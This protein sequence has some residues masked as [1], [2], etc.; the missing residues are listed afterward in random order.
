MNENV[1]EQK[2]SNLKLEEIVERI[3]GATTDRS[4]QL[5]QK[6]IAEEQ[7][8]SRLNLLKAY[9]DKVPLVLQN[10]E[11]S[12]IVDIFNQMDD[13]YI[14]KALFG[15][16]RAVD[17]RTRQEIL[18]RLSREKLALLLKRL[19][20][21][22]DNPKIAGKVLVSLSLLS[23]GEVMEGM[24]EVVIIH[25][26]SDIETAD[27]I[28]ILENS[29][30]AKAARV[31]DILLQSGNVVRLA[32]VTNILK[33][34]EKAKRG[35]ILEQ[36]D[37]GRRELLEGQLRRQ[38]TSSFEEMT[39]KETKGALSSMKP[40]DVAE[41]FKEVSTEK[42]VEILKL[43]EA[44]T[45]AAILT[46]VAKGDTKLVIDVLEEINSKIIV[47]FKKAGKTTQI[48]EEVYMCPSEAILEK[49]DFNIP[50]NLTVLR[51]M[52]KSE[53]ELNLERMPEAKKAEIM[54]LE[55]NQGI[56][57]ELPISVQLFYVGTG[58]KKTTNLEHGL[59]WTRIEEEL[60]TG[61]KTKPV[62]IDL[63]ELDP[64][65]VRIKACRAI[66][67]DNL[68]PLSEVA[69]IFGDAERGGKR[70]DKQIFTQ[71]G[72]IQLSKIV[73]KKG[74]IA[75]INGNHYF[76][77]GHY[78]DALKLGIDPTHV[79]GLSFGDPV[80]WF[81]ADGEEVSP[82]SFNRAAFIVTKDGD[83]YIEKVFMTDVI[84]SNGIKVNWNK[85]NSKKEHGKIILYTS[86]FGFKTEKTAS[87]IDV[88][89]AQGKIFDITEGGD[90]FIPLTGFI[91]SVPREGQD[92]IL[93][94]VN[95]GDRV[96]VSN[97]LPPSLGEV[98]QAMACG[99]HLV[100]NG[101]LDISFKA[102]DFGEKDS[103]VI[104]FSL[105]RAVE[106]FEAARSFMM[107]RDG[108]VFIGTVGGTALGSG[109]PTES[110]GMTFG[111]LAQLAMDLR[112]D[113]AYA[114]DG[115]G[116]SSIVVVTENEAKCLTIPTGG[117]DVAKGEERFINTYWLFF[118]R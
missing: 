104:S 80:G 66:T 100:R 89:V 78:M 56:T 69:K 42:I 117:S 18:E 118:K 107:L 28:K 85:V 90:A 55:K 88:A 68:T 2:M 22:V 52:N 36:M 76:D 99:P 116:S 49:M 7:E 31:L 8:L 72:L 41:Q 59:K 27:K 54:A 13:Y 51:G 37:T 26:I 70:P 34:M 79:P 81:V 10:F 43:C 25:L 58:T 83:V 65:K 15:N 6:L 29:D 108:K 94:N 9:E 40:S 1:A 63:V 109:A 5:L 60:D 75:A 101:Q 67:E 77:Y 64:R 71:L 46:A 74:A 82:P 3:K 47:G 17:N 110:G 32:Y 33:H 4:A 21:G 35:R 97:N 50:E 105:T 53:L 113:D 111:E 73:K 45:A 57:A 91:V 11:I 44:E 112:A 48:I 30:P 14:L 102:E 95:I 115:G 20:V 93:N 38:Y 92:R 39:S 103:S 114:L 62:L 24:E 23:I 84:L 86:L 87:H 12:Q 106:T 16:F 61:E 98:E 96:V 19:S